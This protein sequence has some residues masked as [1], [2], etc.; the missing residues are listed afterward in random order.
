MGCFDSGGSK[1]T[2]IS[3]SFTPAQAKW[4]AKALKLYGPQLGINENV[5]QGQR[6]VP[7]TGI[8]QNVLGNIPNF[9]GTYSTPM[10]V[11]TP[12]FDETGRAISGLLSGETGAEKITPE[13][14][15]K[16]FTEKIET[17]ATKYLKETALPLTDE[18][19][20]GGGFWS[21]ARSKARQ[22]VIQDTADTLATERAKLEWDVTQQNQ[23]LDEARAA[24]TLSAI[25]QAMEYGYMPAQETI[26]NLRIAAAQIEGL[27]ELFGFGS[28][29]QTQEQLELEAE[30]AKF[31]E[32]NQMTD[33]TN[34]SILLQLL[35]MSYSTSYG[36]KDTWGSGLGYQWL[37]PG[38]FFSVA[39][40]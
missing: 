7:F 36:R 19:Y 26:N 18:G 21:T 30:I 27:N 4:L 24:R 38:G 10:T 6:V 15:A 22:D 16:Y 33:P 17:P 23:A 1:E 3:S 25:P 9:L 20:T 40:T 29:Q 2:Q 39:G 37:Q 12:L 13:Q 14:V 11:G 8:Q 28:A 34:L 35:G 5:W 32:Q 31:V